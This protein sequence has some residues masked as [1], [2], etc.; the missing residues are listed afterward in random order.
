LFPWDSETGSAL[1]SGPKG[2]ELL[3]A[4]GTPASKVNVVILDLEAEAT[5]IGPGDPVE[6]GV[7]EVNDAAAIEADEV[8]VLVQLGVEA[9]RRAGVAGPGQE[10]KGDQCS[11]SPIDGHARELGQARMEDVKDLVGGRVVPAVQDR[12]EHGAPL[13]G[14]RQPTLAM[15]GLKT[16]ESSLFLCLS[17]VPEM[18]K[19]IG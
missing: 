14:D 19:Y 18:T 8:M 1:T 2:L 13:H 6:A 3:S 12:F 11:Q 7:L 15:G 17:H 9:R 4:A 10:A 5:N 16:L